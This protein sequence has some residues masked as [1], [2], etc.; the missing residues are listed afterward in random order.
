MQNLIIES[1]Q[2]IRD[3]GNMIRKENFFMAYDVSEC[4]SGLIL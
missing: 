4:D 2:Q 3:W 1:V